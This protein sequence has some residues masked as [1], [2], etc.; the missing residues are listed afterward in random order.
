MDA[1]SR[2]SKRRR[3]SNQKTDP[4]PNS[5][6]NAI[7]EPDAGKSPT[8]RTRKP[9]KG[10]KHA[11]EPVEKG[12]ANAEPA[13]E[14]QDVSPVRS[15]RR[16]ARIAVTGNSVL[17]TSAGPPRP[18]VVE[19]ESTQATPR[20]TKRARKTKTAKDPPPSAKKLPRKPGQKES[21]AAQKLKEETDAQSSLSADRQD[22]H[23]V[24]GV[25]DVPSDREQDELAITAQLAANDAAIQLQQELRGELTDVE[26]IKPTAY[27][28]KFIS[29]CEQNG[30]ESLLEPLGKFILEKLNGKRLIPLKGLENEYQ[31]V[32][33]LLE[34][35][36]VAG[37]GN[38][39]LLLGARGSGK[40]ALVNTAIASLSKSN[41]DDFHV[42]RLNG[43]L[44]TDDKI[45]LRE[46]WQQ[47]GR[48]IG[49]QED[50]EKP[51]SYADTMASLLALLSHPEEI[52][53]P[54]LDP[55][56][57]TTTK[58]VIIILDE[59]DLFSYHPRQT[60]LYNL[61]DIA[62]AKKAPV[63][64]LGLTTKVDVTENL[65]KRVKSRFSH[66][67]TFLPRPRSLD[68]FIDICMAGLKVEKDEMS[69][70]S[71]LLAAKGEV[72]LQGWNSYIQDLFNDA[73]FKSHLQQIYYT[74]K[75][76]KEF[77]SS[78]LVPITTL[79][80]SH[81][82]GYPEV[83]SVKSFK[84]S[85]LACSDPAPLPFTQLSGSTS[86]VSLPLSL[87]LTATRLTALHEPTSNSGSAPAIAS[88]TLSFP[89]V[90]TEYV[91]LLTSAKASASASGAAATPGRVWGKESAKEAWEKLVEW[92]LVMPASGY[93]MGDGKMFR[94][95]VS[96][97]EAVS[98][99]GTSGAGALG[100]WWRD[101]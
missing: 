62:Q 91:R 89:A 9:R 39:L 47:L 87:L 7:P 21:T 50:L 69:S 17:S 18:K 35:T 45:A 20:A 83:P 95:E 93:G 55:N 4:E 80:L 49:P 37:E 72:L 13:Q 28:E 14:K 77:F 42:V 27:A 82:S 26:S 97:E 33:Q 11:A 74:T 92:G 53:G 56:E 46:I 90:Y 8:V 29:L 31:T 94:V 67:Y 16:S 2:P 86:N 10:T 38:S 24:N 78:A 63:A 54:S 43:F 32:F 59:F 75:C 64:V 96:F 22:G 88:L 60:L 61:F 66:R 40:T 99:L 85:T 101:G 51:S 76:P 1:D 3:V 52:T 12:D 48:E 79:A 73:E 36:V 100:R 5:N 58:S 81:A 34:Q 65:E 70:S 19:D 84:S 25:W 98:A 6:P 71:F 30:L 68:D 57:I 44:H 41:R 15:T 23:D